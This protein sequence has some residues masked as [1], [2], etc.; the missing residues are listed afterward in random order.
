[1]AIPG[2]PTATGAPDN[3]LEPVAWMIM[4]IRQALEEAPDGRS[5]RWVRVARGR[6]FPKQNSVRPAAEV[7]VQALL[8]FLSALHHLLFDV[9]RALL[10]IDPQKALVELML[11]LMQAATAPEL[12]KAIG[13]L[14]EDPS[15]EAD[16]A[17]VQQE[18]MA[19]SRALDFIPDPSDLR[20]IGHQ[21]FDLLST[22]T[23]GL[24][25]VAAWET[26]G[27]ARLLAWAYG[28]PVSVRV[29]PL[30]GEAVVVPVVHLG[31]RERW[32]AAGSEPSV[33]KGHWPDNLPT[34]LEIFSCDVSKAEDLREAEALLDALGY[35]KAAA[36]PDATGDDEVL[37]RRLYVFQQLN[38]LPDS[39]ILDDHTRHRLINLD[40]AG[41]NV[42][43][44]QPFDPA[45]LLLIPPPPPP[46]REI[47]EVTVE[48]HVTHTVKKRETLARRG[49]LF[50]VNP[51]ADHSQ[52]EGIVFG[53]PGLRRGPGQDKADPR[54]YYLCGAKVADGKKVASFPSGVTQGWIQHRDDDERLFQED[55]ARRLGCFFVGLEKRPLW[56]KGFEGGALSEGTAY[57]GNYFFSAREVEPWMSGRYGTPTEAWC[58]ATLKDWPPGSISGMYQWAD[59]SQ[60]VAG[61]LPTER[62]YVQAVSLRRGLYKERGTGQL[63][64]QGRIVLGLVNKNM[65]DKT[66][67]LA[68]RYKNALLDAW[69][70]SGWWPNR[71]QED[72]EGSTSLLQQGGGWVQIG[73]PPLRV[74]N[75][76]AAVFIGLYGLQRQNFDTDAYFDSVQVL[77]WRELMREPEAP[78]VVNQDKRTDDGVKDSTPAPRGTSNP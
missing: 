55:R 15:I 63:P 9:E 44:A 27:R 70:W 28:L 75:R 20:T 46:R 39:S 76:H 51:D 58:P 66:A 78:P 13:T 64:D 59:L 33:C 69:A 57:G 31:V 29:K 50:L 61:T 7:A 34:S 68:T 74:H 22:G 48:K 42:A 26:M 17:A 21:L 38:D 35:T 56:G 4:T 67:P 14:L 12:G 11:E 49:E 36:A 52:D 18:L 60:E 25:D 23:T 2:L 65:L 37:A 1:M 32:S 47:Q 3:V 62:L 24:N 40:F 73:T 19:P 43:P 30:K 53:K 16:F 45:R 5:P 6:H 72:L 77:W 41:Q 71:L 8:D 54:A 10:H